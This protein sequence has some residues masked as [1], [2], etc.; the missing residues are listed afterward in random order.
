MWQPDG[1]R[2]AGHRPHLAHQL[3]CVLWSFV[4]FRVVAPIAGR[5]LPINPQ[6]HKLKSALISTFTKPETRVY[7]NEHVSPTNE[8]Y[9]APRLGVSSAAAA[10]G[11]FSRPR[12]ALPSLATWWSQSRLVTGWPHPPTHPPI[13]SHPVPSHSIAHPG[14]PRP[15]WLLTGTLLFQCEHRLVHTYLCVYREGASAARLAACTVTPCKTSDVSPLRVMSIVDWHT[16]FSANK[17]SCTR[18]F[19]CAGKGGSAARLAAC[20]VTPCKTSH[21]SPLRAMS[22]TLLHI[23][24]ALLHVPGE[25]Q[26]GPSTIPVEPV[27]CCPQ[28]R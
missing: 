20:T 1:R 2:S 14:R 24:C 22:I 9:K 25:L 12:P 11:A 8:F 3:T 4:S 23:M 19:A 16:V 17:Y 21:V 15:P 10:F 7:Q 28:A 5:V 18:I 27:D 6:N 26:H 13:P